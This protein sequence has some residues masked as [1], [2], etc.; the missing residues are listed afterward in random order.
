[1]D[2]KLVFITNFEY[3]LPDL[4]LEVIEWSEKSD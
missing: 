1:M 2:F 3:E 4:D